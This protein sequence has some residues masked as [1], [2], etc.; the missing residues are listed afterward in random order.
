MFKKLITVCLMCTF[1]FSLS[2]CGNDKLSMIGSWDVMDEKGNVWSL[3]LKD[4]NT[5]IMG[6][7]LLQVGGDYVFDSN[8]LTLTQSSENL[9]Y[10]IEAESS[11]SVKFYSVD[12]SG[13]RTNEENG[14]MTKK[15][16]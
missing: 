6:L 14:T 11:S 4:N 8:Q 5:F 16:N 12:D 10:E 7:G 15:D 9:I 3:E 2:A 13:K 1:L